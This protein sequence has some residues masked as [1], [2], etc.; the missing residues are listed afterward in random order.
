MFIPSSIDEAWN[1]PEEK[2]DLGGTDLD[3]L[4][5][6]GSSG[7]RT[8]RRRD[9]IR[10]CRHNISNPGVRLPLRGSGGSHRQTREDQ[11]HTERLETIFTR[12]VVE[13]AKNKKDEYGLEIDCQQNSEFD[14]AL[15]THDSEAHKSS[16]GTHLHVCDAHNAFN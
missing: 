11:S 1:S 4:P 10:P 14:D 3:N 9:L 5:L 6:E 2:N 15:R 7:V 12:S 16:H 13:R 8:S